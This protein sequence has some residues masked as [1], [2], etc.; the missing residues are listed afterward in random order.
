VR[1]CAGLVSI[2]IVAASTAAYADSSGANRSRMDWSG[3]YIGV[4]GGGAWTDTD[5]GLNLDPGSNPVHSPGYAALVAA[6]GPGSANDTAFTGGGQIGFN[7]QSG[8]LVFGLEGD[9]NSLRSSN[10]RQITGIDI[11][12]PTFPFTH[13]ESAST[14]WFATIRPRIGFLTDPSTFV[15]VTGGLA[16]TELKYTY[17]YREP[18]DGVSADASASEIKA[19][20]TVGGGGELAIDRH[21]SL[22]AEYLYAEFGDVAESARLIYAPNPGANSVINSSADLTVQTARGGLNYRF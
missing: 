20:W 1:V 15:Y 4:N 22:K 13:T 9:F 7:F 2:L 19:G 10:T 21:W 5:M 17:A 14:D 12:Q 3:F 11:T 6:A 8:G 16:L 18:K